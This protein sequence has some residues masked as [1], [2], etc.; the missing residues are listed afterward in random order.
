MKKHKKTK[1]QPIEQI[2]L[3]NIT[4]CKRKRGIVKK[5]IEIANLCMLDVSLVLY[6]K[7]K[8]KVVHYTSEGFSCSKALDLVNEHF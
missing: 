2:N 5:A 8:N 3:R 6:D 4:Y 7:R 1:L